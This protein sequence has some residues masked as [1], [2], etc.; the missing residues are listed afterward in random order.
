LLRKVLEHKRKQ[1]TKHWRK[2]HGTELRSL[3]SSPNI[4]SVI[5][6]SRTLLAEFVATCR[7]IVGNVKAGEHFEDKT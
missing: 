3:Y 1:V 5:K 6:Y 7:I 4:I 2:L